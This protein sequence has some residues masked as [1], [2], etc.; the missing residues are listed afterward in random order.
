MSPD[1][2]ILPV[3]LPHQRL[4]HRGRDGSVHLD[5][6]GTG[7]PRLGHDLTPV[8]FRR[9]R[10]RPGGL[11]RGHAAA[12]RQH[13]GIGEELGSRGERGVVDR[14]GFDVAHQGRPRQLGERPAVARHVAHRGDAPVERVPEPL[15]HQVAPV[16]GAGIGGEMH[17]GVD[18]AGD[19]PPPPQ[20]EHLGAG[21]RLGGIGGELGGDPAVPEEQRAPRPGGRAG[22]VDHGHV[23]QGD[24]TCRPERSEGPVRLSRSCPEQVPRFAREDDRRSRKPARPTLR[25][26]TSAWRERLGPP[27]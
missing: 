26:V 18:Q 14:R 16:A 17:V 3:S 11:A 12:H 21:R 23:G 8:G 27:I 2:E 20:V 24:L 1:P 19:H 15:D 6:R 4:Q 9:D 22:A 10:P 7:A 5:R 13:P 25:L